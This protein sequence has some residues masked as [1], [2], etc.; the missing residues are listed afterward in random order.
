MD[1]CTCSNV[2]AYEELLRAEPNVGAYAYES[3]THL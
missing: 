3:P 2:W 1:I